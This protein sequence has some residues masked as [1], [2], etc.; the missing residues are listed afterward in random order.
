MNRLSIEQRAKILS[1]LVEGNSIRATCRMTDTA[2]GTVIK[3][4]ADVGAAC[5]RYQ[6]MALRELPCRKIQCD[7]IWSFC[8]AKEK[9]VPAEHRGEL[10]FGDVY[11]W[12]AICADTKLCA[13]WLV[14]KRDADYAIAFIDDLA[15]RL[16][17]RIQLSTDG[18][19]AY[20]QAVDKA[21]GG[22]DR[23]RRADKDVRRATVPGKAL[24]PRAVHWV[25]EASDYRRSL[26][27][28]GIDKL[29]R[30]PKLDHAHENA[31]V[32]AAD[33]RIQQKD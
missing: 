29:C 26:P 6:D 20:L 2:K 9:N 13:S 8:Y 10:G 32:H 1:C 18:L 3:L 15:G 5:S 28:R 19:H 4:L 25:N 14:G 12:T 17:N 16:A 24:Q 31:P 7:E 22:Q 30:A 21:F 23:L 33:K 11:T 27:K